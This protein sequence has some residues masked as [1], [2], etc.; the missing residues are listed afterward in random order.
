MTRPFASGAPAPCASSHAAIM[1]TASE[2]CPEGS[3]CRILVRLR[4][5]RCFYADPSLAGPPARTGRPRRHGPK[6]KCKDPRT[7]P[8]PSAEYAC[9]DAG[10]RAVRVRAWSGLHPKVQAHAGHGSRGPA[11]IVRGTSDS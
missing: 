6:M 3:P 11:P 7:Q 1:A 8:D 9:E 2:G 5:G 4:A 10:Y